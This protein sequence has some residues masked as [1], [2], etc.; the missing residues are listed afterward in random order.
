MPDEGLEPPTRPA[1]DQ[2]TT[3]QL[4]LESNWTLITPRSWGS[5]P[6]PHRLY[7]LSRKPAP[8]QVVNAQDAKKPR[9]HGAFPMRRRGL[10]PPPG[11]PGP[12]PQPCHSGVRSVQCV[13][14]VQNVREFGRIG[15]NGRPGC[16]RGCCHGGGRLWMPAHLRRDRTRTPRRVARTACPTLPSASR[17][18]RAAWYR[19]AGVPERRAERPRRALRACRRSGGGPRG[20][21]S[22]PRRSTRASGPAPRCGTR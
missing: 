10:E 21:G 8:P 14:I 15:R 11:Y 12:G 6:L 20:I 1:S 17:R 7:V 3:Q 13:H 22:S 5:H 9:K 18:R 2:R 4:R 19:R 16:C